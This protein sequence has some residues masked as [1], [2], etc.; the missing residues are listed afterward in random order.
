MTVNILIQIDKLV[1]LI[2]SPVFTCEETH[3]YR[4]ELKGTNCSVTDLRLQLLE[5]EKYPYLYKC[6]Y[7]LLMLLPQSG[8]FAAL[9]NR[10]NSVSSIGFLHPG[11]R[12]YVSSSIPSG[13]TPSHSR[14][15]SVAEVFSTYQIHSPRKSIQDTHAFPTSSTA[16]PSTAAYDR[17]NRLGK[18]REDGIIR[19]DQLLEKFRSVQDKARRAQRSMGGD[20]LDEGPDFGDMRMQDGMGTKELA[21]PPL[22]P[23]VP[24]KEQAPVVPPKRSSGLGRQFGRLGVTVPGRG[25]RT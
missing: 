17:P 21:R 20:S 12:A 4:Q 19:W 16:A 3:L 18:S 23:P 1:Q 24:Q 8:A 15:G 11:S 14:Q 9:K 25:K 10:L 5:P 13:V 22:G 2:E 7:G 6:L